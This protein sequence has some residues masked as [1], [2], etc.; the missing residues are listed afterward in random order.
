MA[1]RGDY[2]TD[3]KFASYEKAGDNGVAGTDSE[4]SSYGGTPDAGNTVL[5][6]SGLDYLRPDFTDA[7]LK[8]G[9]CTDDMKHWSDPPYPMTIG[10]IEAD[11]SAKPNANDG[12]DLQDGAKTFKQIK[13]YKIRQGVETLA[14]ITGESDGE[15]G[16][17]GF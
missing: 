13:H 3:T 16:Y 12:G 1:K 14:M 9:G 17:G 2:S 8:V 6:G 5:P 7:D 15:G 11:R 4:K 10:R